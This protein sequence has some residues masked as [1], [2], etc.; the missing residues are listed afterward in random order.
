MAEWVYLHHLDPFIFSWSEGMGIRWYG[1]AYIGGMLLGHW[2]VLRLIKKNRSPL[3]R[4]DLSNFVTFAMCGVLVGGRL[5][6]CTFYQ[7][8]LWVQLGS[9]FPFWGVLEVHKGGMSSHGGII[10][11]FLGTWLFAQTKK[12]SF[13]HLL[14]LVAFGGAIGIIFGR[15]ANF[16]NGELYGRVI[17]GSALWG[18]QFPSEITSWYYHWS[19]S[20]LKSLK[21]VVVQLGSIRNPFGEA[22]IPA[23]E[24]MWEFL[25]SSPQRFAADILSTLNT[26]LYRVDQGHPGVIK[27]LKEILPV[28]HPSQLYQ[29]FLEG[30]IPMVVLLWMWRKPKKSGWNVGVWAVAYFLMRIV[31]EQFREP[32]AYIGMDVLG[33]TRGQWLS[34]VSLFGVGAYL[35]FLHYNRKNLDSY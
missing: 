7:P 14:D 6:F 9:S 31:G 11:L 20:S 25:V 8:E 24:T 10:G 35:L 15:I 29:A 3:S 28:R 19:E 17:E 34:V 32:D 13:F 30:L 21:K 1:M 18:V 27:A 5:G 33:L 23:S 16:I 26:I 12:Y 2:F 4:K 22:K